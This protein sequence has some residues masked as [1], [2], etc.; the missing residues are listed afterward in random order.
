MK[1]QTQKILILLVIMAAV[2]V[3]IL[4]GAFT[5]FRRQFFKI[6]QTSQQ[7][8]GDNDWLEVSTS[9]ETDPE[10]GAV[11]VSIF[12]QGNMDKGLDLSTEQWQSTENFPN[13][14][15]AGLNELNYDDMIVVAEDQIADTLMSAQ[16]RV[17]VSWNSPKT[18][19]M[20]DGT[21]FKP[22]FVD[23]FKQ[24]DSLEAIIGDQNI[25]GVYLLTPDN[26]YFSQVAEKVEQIIAEHPQTTGN[27]FSDQYLSF[28]QPEGYQVAPVN[29]LSGLATAQYEIYPKGDYE[30]GAEVV[31]ELMTLDQIAANY[32][33][34]D[35]ESSD[36]L[37]LF[38]Q[39]RTA[40]QGKDF[41][42][43]NYKQTTINDYL[44]TISSDVGMGESEV[45]RL[46][47]I[48]KISPDFYGILSGNSE[49]VAEISQSL[50]F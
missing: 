39:R 6:P 41:V 13:L 38:I 24:D 44:V 31:L 42:Q 34:E 49:V 32:Q 35:L 1:K 15:Y 21:E 40:V 43:V 50:K 19:Q 5:N 9:D 16:W 3:V 14:F 45:S 8:V 25:Q 10:A 27:S 30:A 29:N 18:L 36:N 23:F 4:L 48:Y 2:G 12:T 33:V 20:A 7:Q 17:F 28:V 11:F 26:V 22:E 47:Y 46:L 37:S